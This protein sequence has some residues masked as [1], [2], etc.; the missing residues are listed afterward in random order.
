MDVEGTPEPEEG[1]PKSEGALTSHCCSGGARR[2]HSG[3]AL[4][5]R[6]ALEELVAV[7]IARGRRRRKQK[8]G[9]IYFE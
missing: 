7:P 8:S 5:Y 3:G 4:T 9:K 6:C 1:T 2:C